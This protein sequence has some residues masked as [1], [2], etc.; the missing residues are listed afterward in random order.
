MQGPIDAALGL[1]AAGN[2]FLQGRDVSGFWPDAQTFI[3]TKACE[4]RTPPDNGQTDFPLLAADPLDWF[5]SLKPW[6]RG[7][8]LHN[9]PA[10]LQPGQ[11]PGLS[12]R[13]S[14]AF[15]GGGPRWLVEAVGDGRSELWESFQRF[16]DR[17]DPQ[18]KIWLTT[19]IRQGEHPPFD[20]EAIRLEEAVRDF[21][22]VLP[23]IAGFARLHALDNFAELFERSLRILEGEPLM[24]VADDADLNRYGHAGED[25][26]RAY[27]A[28][29]PAWVFG[30]MGSWNDLGGV[31]EPYEELSE[32]L[33]RA[34]CDVVCGVA[35]ATYRG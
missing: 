31:P 18:Q 2:A 34:L 7:L 17:E 35:T 32:R 14:V 20:A 30:G 24:G 10:L 4:F 23:E 27:A 13:M 6:C 15:V 12:E 19:W 29:G 9:S 26:L 8:R 33:F 1:V 5:A 11:L 3:Y 22:V 21:R 16:G 25:A 28:V